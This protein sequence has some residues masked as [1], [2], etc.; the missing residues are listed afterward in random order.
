VQSWQG[1]AA[2]PTREYSQKQQKKWDYQQEFFI[3]PI[4]FKSYFF[5]D[6]SRFVHKKAPYI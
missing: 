6:I 2:Y 5:N 1:T 3:R 4:A